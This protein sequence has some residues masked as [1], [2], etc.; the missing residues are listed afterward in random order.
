MR[1]RWKKEGMEEFLDR[2]AEKGF[3]VQVPRRI[4]EDAIS[5]WLDSFN[6]S[7]IAQYRRA[8]IRAGF[9]KPRADGRLYDII[10]GE[11]A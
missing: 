9:L 1:N 5:E 7:Y 11:K 6:P 10:R 2:L 3:S 4:L 8:L